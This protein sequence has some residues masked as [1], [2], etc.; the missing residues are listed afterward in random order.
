VAHP[1][2]DQ[3]RP[4]ASKETG[5]VDGQNMAVQYRFAENQVDRL[6]ALA[7]NLVRRRVAVIATGS[8]ASK[9]TAPPSVFAPYRNP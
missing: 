1:T 2:S 5:Y 8:A 6:P 3:Q 9:T 4:S 7:A